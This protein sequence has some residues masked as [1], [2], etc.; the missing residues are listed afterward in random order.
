MGGGGEWDEKRRST[1]EWLT[2]WPFNFQA[3]WKNSPSQ[4]KPIFRLKNL[5]F[6]QPCKLTLAADRSRTLKYAIIKLNAYFSDIIA[7]ENF[8]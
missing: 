7:L 4:V 6:L 1:G 8:I 3:R 5:S 2:G